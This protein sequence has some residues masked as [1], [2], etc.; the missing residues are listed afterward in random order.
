MVGLLALLFL[1]VPLVELWVII[2][3]AGGI[4]GAETLVVLVGVSLAGAWLVRVQGL[5]VLRRV[6]RALGERRLP[7]AE[8]VDGVL[9]LGA[10]ALML[11]PGF[12]T[13]GVG[14]LL[15]IPPTRAVVRTMLIGR[16]RGRIGVYQ[17][18]AA[19]SGGPIDVDGV[20]TDDR[21]P[22]PPTAGPTSLGP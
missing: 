14:L 6:Q 22:D 17:A 10:G 5:G 13:D 19:P 7:A 2:Q 12:I 4:G 9:I 18:T 20:V 16:F 3:V 11:T 15:L 21:M 8:L 1:V